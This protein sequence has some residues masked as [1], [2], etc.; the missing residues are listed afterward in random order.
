MSTP[1]RSTQMD[2]VPCQ[3][4]AVIASR[5]VMAAIPITLALWRLALPERSLGTTGPR[6]L[7]DAAFALI[8][9]AH[10]FLLAAAI[11]S[12]VGRKLWP[13]ATRTEGFVFAVAA[14]TGLPIWRFLEEQ[15]YLGE[16]RQPRTTLGRRD[17]PKAGTG[18]LRWLSSLRPGSQ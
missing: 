2:P 5:A 15:V 4:R 9:T 6:A 3:R 10:L 1:L 7:A 12:Q 13:G 17:E 16:D 14:G 8:L 11:G 18:A